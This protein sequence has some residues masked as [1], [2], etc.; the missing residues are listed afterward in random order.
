M[1]NL[2]RRNHQR[3]EKKR[4]EGK[5]IRT[6]R[7]VKCRQ[8]LCFVLLLVNDIAVSYIH[9]LEYWR[10]YRKNFAPLGHETSVRCNTVQAGV[11]VSVSRLC[12]CNMY[13]CARVCTCLRKRHRIE[14]G[15]HIDMMISNL[16]GKFCVKNFNDLK[17]FVTIEFDF[18]LFL[19]VRNNINCLLC[20]EGERSRYS[21]L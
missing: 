17:T 5:K 18:I 10:F 12:V 14:I 15:Q 2:R 16:S 9:L 7:E 4:K 3:K 8:L 1:V 21:S 11:C 19:P 20:E 6:R 13:V